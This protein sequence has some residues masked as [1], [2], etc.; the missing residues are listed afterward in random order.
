MKQRGTGTFKKGLGLTQKLVLLLLVVGLLPFAINAAVSY[1][2]AATA[3]E[4]TADHQLEGIRELKKNQ[5]LGYL[6]ERM[7]DMVVLSELIQSLRHEAELKLKAVEGTKV[8]ALER[9][10]SKRRSD[11]LM[12]A[13]SPTTINAI[14][15]FAEAFREEGNRVDGSLWNGYKEKYGP[16]YKSFSSGHG[17]YDLFL[18]SA[19]GDIV[20]TNA[21]ESDLGQNLVSGSLKT[22]GLGRLFTKALKG[23]A[24]ED[25]SAY[26]PSNNQQAIF[27]GAPVQEEGRTLGIVALQIPTRDVDGIVQAREGLVSS[28]E[29]YLVGNA[30]S[31]GLRSN[32]V[33]K[34]GHIGEPHTGPDVEL[35]LAG[36]A[37]TLHKIGT[38]GVYE[39][40]SYA[41]INIEGLNWGLVTNGALQ[42]V[43]VP[44]AEGEAE[45]LMQKYLKA[46]GYHD[47]FLFS[48]DG[49]AFYTAAKESDYQTNLLSGKY[50]NTSLGR[51]LKQVLSSRKVELADFSLYAPSGDKPA[52][53]AATPVVEQGEIV[54]LVAVQLP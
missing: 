27:V 6:E 19:K 50:S 41:P 33:V 16:W 44:K 17:Y 14:Q 39:L 29:S 7:G 48:P 49:Y 46:Y 10:F 5:V 22:S 43:V 45:D 31:P 24:I 18:I 4:E 21:E 1:W 9:Y 11:T 28:F 3:L 35:A 52:F 37:G 25:Y 34:E 36:K 47:I 15:E 20:Y 32:R 51:L 40:S 13:S 8:Q 53:F 30:Q 23:V 12:V 54:M 2:Q 42:E 26:A 38:T